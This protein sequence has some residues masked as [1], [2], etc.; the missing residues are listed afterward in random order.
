MLQG[1]LEKGQSRHGGRQ[2]IGSL[3]VSYSLLNTWD[4]NWIDPEGENGGGRKE[5]VLKMNWAYYDGYMDLSHR[6]FI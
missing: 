1:A 5:K 4:K 6:N 3:E 2:G